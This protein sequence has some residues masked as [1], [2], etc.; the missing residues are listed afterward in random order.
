MWLPVLNDEG[1]VRLQMRNKK[2]IR[3]VFFDREGVVQ[4]LPD[5]T[6]PDTVIVFGRGVGTVTLAGAPR[7]MAFERF[8]QQGPLALLPL[9]GGSDGE[10]RTAMV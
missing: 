8:T 3:S 1:S 5:A 7:G 4:V 9:P 6:K 10:R 2:F